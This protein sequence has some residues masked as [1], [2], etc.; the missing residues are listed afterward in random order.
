MVRQKQP[1]S[2]CVSFWVAVSSAAT[3][4]V[5]SENYRTAGDPAKDCVGKSLGRLLKGPHCQLLPRKDQIITNKSEKQQLT[6]KGR[7]K[8]GWAWW[9]LGWTM[10]KTRLLLPVVVPGEEMPLGEGCC[11]KRSGKLDLAK[12]DFGKPSVR[13]SPAVTIGRYPPE[14]SDKSKQSMVAKN[15]YCGVSQRCQSDSQTC[16]YL[17]TARH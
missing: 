3:L 12:C 13:L 16:W 1:L 2:A 9:K 17:N 5:Q 15:R 11:V 6:H 7:K 8:S 14:L 4:S 10:G